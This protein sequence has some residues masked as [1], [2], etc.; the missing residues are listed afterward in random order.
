M[1]SAMSLCH[2]FHVK[3]IPTSLFRV[4]HVFER[5]FDAR[6]TAKEAALEIVEIVAPPDAGRHY[7]N[8]ALDLIFC[9]RQG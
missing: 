9:M 4:E 1:C 3:E 5:L 8:R 7:L 6:F 2:V